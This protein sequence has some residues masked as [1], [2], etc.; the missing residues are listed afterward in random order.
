VTLVAPASFEAEQYQQLQHAVE[1]LH[2]SSGLGVLAVSSPATGDGKT[3]TAINLAVTLA[4]TPG[5]RV[6]LVDA[7]LRQAAV[8]A[9][10]GLGQ[11]AG[12]GLADAILDAELDLDDVV[13]AR[14]PSRLSVLLAGRQRPATPY[15]LLTSPRLET[16]LMEARQRYDHVVLDMPPV[17]AVPDCRA[18]EK[19]IDG[20]LLVVAAD[21][22]P[23]ALLEEALDAMEPSR[24]IGL[25]FNGDRRAG[26][27]RRPSA[28]PHAGARPRWGRR[29]ARAL[30]GAL[31][32]LWARR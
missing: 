8:G 25:V 10:L 32:G 18:L 26:G 31:L 20:F 21:R 14:P 17:V 27:Y 13:Q 2:R 1:Q 28:P 16:L 9:R 23:R 22:T 11:P 15:E 24:L 29:V 5:S 12:P 30:G 6:L 3:L 4:Q 7:D 19:W